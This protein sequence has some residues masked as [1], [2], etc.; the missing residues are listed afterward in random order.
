[1]PVPLAEMT[2][3]KFLEWDE[4]PEHSEWVDGKVEL[5][6]GVTLPD[7]EVHIFLLMMVAQFVESR[8]LGKVFMRPFQMKI[9]PDLP[10]RAPD[11][12]FVKKMDLSRLRTLYFDGPAD[13]VIEV[14]SPD[15]RALDRDKKF[16]EYEEGGVPEFWL[17]DPERNEAEFF[18]LGADKMYHAAPLGEDGI[19]RS[20]VLDGLWLKV[21]W[22]W[23]DP[24]PDIIKVL[25]ELGVY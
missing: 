9:G 24:M 18:L 20:K 11:V 8:K 15:S 21:G 6:D 17:I 1:M 14:I 5:M 22:L 13:L 2:Y 3:E 7:H 4:A 16:Y 23:E 10:G 19:Y 25:K 12:F